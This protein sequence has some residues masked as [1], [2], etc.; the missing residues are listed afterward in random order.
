MVQRKRFPAEAESFEVTRAR[1]WIERNA[2]SDS[3][4]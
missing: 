1:E 3:L 2:P 4:R